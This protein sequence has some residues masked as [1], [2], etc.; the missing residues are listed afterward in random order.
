MKY[1]GTDVRTAWIIL[2][3][4]L[5]PVRLLAQSPG[6]LDVSFGTGGT[7]LTPIGVDNDEVGDVA[8]QRDGKIVVA[9]H[10]WEAGSN[11]FAVA[12]YLRDGA[13]DPSF[14]G[15]GV[16]ITPFAGVTCVPQSVVVQ[17]DGKIIVGGYTVDQTT[18][19]IELA[20]VRY[21]PNGNL[22]TS[23]SG[24]GKVTTD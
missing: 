3:V 20:L 17:P 8:R 1:T 4:W 24:D 23:V 10:T 18:S 15:D 7:V 22:D 12:R 2:F 19:H 16:V 13:L 5:L 6:E 9:G 11:A 21:L 14:G